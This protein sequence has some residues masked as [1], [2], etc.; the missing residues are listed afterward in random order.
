MFA[1]IANFIARHY[2]GIIA[3]WIIVLIIAIPVAPQVFN[4]V[5][6]E[7]TEM[8]PKDVESIIAQDFINQHFPSA[9]REGTTIIVLTNE[10]VFNEE[11]KEAVFKIKNGIFNETHGGRIDGEVRVDTLYDAIE[12]YSTGVLKN[13]NQRYHQIKEMVDLTAYAV[14]GIPLEFRTLWQETNKSCFMVFGIPAMHLATWIQINMTYPLWNVSTV[15]SVAY[16]QTKNLLITS[17]E[18]QGLNESERSLAM[19]WYSTYIIG[20]NATRGTPLESMPSERASSALLGFENFLLIAPLPSDFKAFLYSIYSNF[21]LTDWNDY[22]ALN[23]FCKELFL[24]QMQAMTSEIPADYA[25]SFSSY[26]ET[27]YSLWNASSSEPND[28]QFR[29][30]VGSSVDALSNAVGGEEGAFITA[31]YSYLG[32]DG[33]N[34]DSLISMFTATNIAELAS[35]DLWLVFEVGKIPSNASIFTFQ[36]LSHQIVVNHTID[37]FPLPI[38]PALLSSFVNTPKNDTMIISLTF[39]SDDENISLGKESVGIIREIVKDSTSGSDGITT[40]VTGSDAISLDLERSTNEDIERIDPITI[41]LVLILIGLFFRSFIASSVPPMIIG[42]AMGVSFAAVYA[43]GSFFLPIHYSVPTLMVTSMMG[44]GCD[45]CIFVLSRYREERRN[46]LSKEESVKTAV[47]WAGESIATS[48][49]TVIIGFG[50][51]SL[52]RFEML[53]SMGI[54]LALGITIALIAA[55]T[56]LP[57]ILMLLGDRIFW[58][59]KMTGVKKNNG[60]K[61]KEGYFTKSAKFAVKHAKAIVL[62]ALV[63]SIPAT[64]LVLTLETSYDFIEAMPDNESKLGIEV[65]GESFGAGKMMP[66]LIAVEMKN[67]II[68]NDSF[69]VGALDAIEDLCKELSNLSSVAEITSPTRPLG[70]HEPIDYANLSLYPEEQAAQ[71]MALM[72][73]MISENNSKV[74][75]ITVSFRED[76]FAKESIDSINAIRSLAS[77]FAAENNNVSATYIAGS[78]AIMYDISTLVWDDFKVMEVLAIIGIYIVL[79]IVLG[80]L[81]SPLRSIITI[82]LSISWTIAVTMLLFNFLQGVPILWLMPMVLTVVCLGLGM[83]YDI[84]ITTRIREEAQKGKS[85]TDAIVHAMERT[86]G[87]ITA[88][89]IIMAAAFGTMMLSEGA[90]L[91]EFGFAL[92]FAIL[93]DSTIVRIYLVP[94]AMSLLGK[95]NWYAPGKL[96]RV[97]RDKGN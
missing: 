75:L 43:I 94:A 93:L 79:M 71:Y 85:D 37:N 26:F 36:Q 5:E 51:L 66:T 39:E 56:L 47:T 45:Y 2:K 17:L 97:R 69:D 34:N 72:R 35:I 64:Y 96:Q 84:F 8:A 29:G 41:V 78:T 16:E 57:S 63:I 42:I 4:I 1:R 65:L 18:T 80:S 46:G 10:D 90:L 91:R 28:L 70:E 6:Y 77:E 44:A 50:V 58:P 87:I 59:S 76:P 38:I 19:G 22:H 27:F 31:I 11:M 53:K 9:G 30:I 55:L 33:W 89:G 54:G 21:D 81:I 74:V 24:S 15:D 12:V 60:E 61:N 88:C 13:I 25:Q 83:D 82:L 49:A 52:G 68:V 92:A 14:F 73:G 48:G 86:G 32:W 7:E 40:Y 67:P 20:W 62:V 95:W 3:A 23:A